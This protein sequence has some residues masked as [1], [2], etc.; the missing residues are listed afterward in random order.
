MD[1][2][3]EGREKA[4]LPSSPTKA[5]LTKWSCGTEETKMSR[6]LLSLFGAVALAGLT[7][8]TS[9]AQGHAVPVGAGCGCCGDSVTVVQPAQQSYQRFSYEPSTT[10]QGIGVPSPTAVY[11]SQQSVSAPP[12]ITYAPQVQSYRRFSY[13]PSS[14]SSAGRVKNRPAYFY[15][16]TDPR[17][18]QN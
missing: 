12:S 7:V 8:A 13:Q 9:H 14:Q 15:P 6:L 11:P 18:Y 1:L 4:P 10:G 5:V 3:S 2:T 17:R 16:K